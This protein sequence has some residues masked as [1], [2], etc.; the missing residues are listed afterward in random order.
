VCFRK[1]GVAAV[2]LAAMFSDRAPAQCQGHWLNGMGP[3]G[4]SGVGYATVF[5]DPD[6]DGP[7]ESMLVVGGSLGNGVESP[8]SSVC[9]WEGQR[10]TQFGSGS[11]VIEGT[12]RSFCVAPDNSLVVGGTIGPRN[13]PTSANV[14]RWDGTRWLW[15]GSPLGQSGTQVNAVCALP[16]GDVV[17]GG[18]FAG[19]GVPAVNGLAK[20]NGTN[21]SLL[22]E[23]TN[24]AVYALALGP[25]GEL[26][27]GGEFTMI[28]GVSASGLARWDGTTWRPFGQVVGSPVWGWSVRALAT[29]ADTLYVG[30]SFTSVD[31]LPVN[32]IAR[33]NELGWSP[34]G[35]GLGGTVIALAGMPGGGVVAGGA[36]Y[37]SGPPQLLRLAHWNGETWN[38][39]GAGTTGNVYGIAADP[40]QPGRIGA[41]GSFQ[42]VGAVG[43]NV[44]A[45]WEDHD[46]HGTAAGINAP[47]VDAISDVNGDLVIGG[48]FR[49]LDGTSA[50]YIARK[51]ERGWEPLGSLPGPVTVLRK[52][53]SGALLAA[54][55]VNPTTASSSALGRWD[56]SE[57][58]VLTTFNG[59]FNDIF[60]DGENS[61]VVAG[62]FVV[63]GTVEVSCLARLD[64]GQ[65]AVIGTALGSPYSD[66]QVNA[67]ARISNGDL[68]VT[69]DFRSAGGV[70]VNRV[71]RWDGSQWN[72]YGSGL[73][74]NSCPSCYCMGEALVIRPDSSLVVAGTFDRAGGVPA[75]G[76]ARWTGVAWESLAPTSSS[77]AL[78][79]VNAANGDLL[80]GA[81]WGSVAGVFRVNGTSWTRVGDPLD[82][83]VTGILPLPSGTN[84][85]SGNFS[86]AG[87]RVA[88]KLA[89]WKLP[90]AD[91]N[92]DGDWG[93][94]A[95]VE[96]FFRCL[97]G[98]C[99]GTCDADFNGDGDTGTDQDIEAFFRVLAGQPC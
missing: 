33:Y 37:Q 30:G 36:F 14:G 97:A 43:A 63:P 34:L 23:A 40:A 42:A 53:P 46:W 90:N 91:F 24:G 83:I 56:G 27:A 88:N 50:S 89:I 93:S 52:L 66:L 16:N 44:A 31:G 22:G 15:F 41:C 84:V 59:A 80:V 10:W 99:C 51:G 5:W 92:S 39:L 7:R 13:S 77:E 85:V 67:V 2:G 3:A 21:W 19:F 17:A 9:G 57:W 18:S 60:I 71:A 70:T 72:A 94:S 6:G 86:R 78:A 54:Y 96:A 75:G 20:W 73:E 47:I 98:H 55:R 79:V 32:S 82:W 61:Y 65:W 62:R 81:R 45:I 58:T 87:A 69:G 38:A 74:P 76:L 11:G 64:Q 29:S 28:G 26:I 95:D 48:A 4:L 8:S 49:T 1:Y 25:S 35:V 68:V 12:V